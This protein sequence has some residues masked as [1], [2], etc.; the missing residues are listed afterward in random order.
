MQPNEIQKRR[1][2]E[3]DTIYF[4][5]HLYCRHQHHSK[6]RLCSD[7]QTLYEYAANRIE[8]CPFMETKTFCN[9]CKVHCYGDEERKKIKEVMRYSGPRMLF[10][11]PK[12]AICHGI[13]SIRKKDEK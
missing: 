13:N 11:H 3:K 10:Y 6:N 4:M 8:K 5:I 9:T 12:M 1:N 2:Q 7:C